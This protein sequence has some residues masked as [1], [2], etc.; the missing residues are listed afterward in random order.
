MLCELS[1]KQRTIGL[2]QSKR[3]IQDGRAKKAFIAKDADSRLRQPVEQLCISM[4]VPVEHAETMRDLG[5][6]CG[7]EVGAAVAVVL[8]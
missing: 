4:G 3:A 7:I 2:K 6:A 8:K 1:G 5:S